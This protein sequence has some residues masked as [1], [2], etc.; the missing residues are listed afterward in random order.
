MVCP[1]KEGER[2]VTLS[3]CPGVVSSGR[4]IVLEH[5]SDPTEREY[6]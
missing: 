2:P 1:F 4:S 3:A 5:D 6:C